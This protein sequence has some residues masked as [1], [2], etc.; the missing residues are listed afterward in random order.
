[1]LDFEHHRVAFI[2]LRG[3]LEDGADFLTLDGL[4]RIEIVADVAARV[5]VLT[6]DER[7]FLGDLDL[8]LLVV[9]GHDRG[10][11]DDV[12][13]GIAA[14]RAQY[15]GKIH[16]VAGKTTDADRGAARYGRERRRVA[17]GAGEIDDAGAADGFDESA[18]RL[19]ALRAI[20]QPI[21]A[22]LGRFVGRDF[23]DDRLDDHLRTTN[24]E[25]VD[26][27]HQRI[28][29]LGRCRDH[30][31]VGF[32]FR[33]DRGATADGRGVGRCRAGGARHR[34][35]AAELFLQFGSDFLGIGVTQVTHP[36]VAAGG[37][38]GIEIGDQRACA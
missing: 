27:R 32:G 29:G 31:R 37:E 12:G 17:R 10:R 19:I 15:R 9:H 34:C 35:R 36:R 6:G 20:H 5:R 22:E 26:H 21:D 16:A 25:L 28:H 7:D 11:G 3:D 1:M 2:D 4:E 23:D 24:I 38:R 33:P 30:E 13:G 8:G 14:Q 18:D